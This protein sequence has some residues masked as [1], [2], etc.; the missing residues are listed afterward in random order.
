MEEHYIELDY[1]DNVSIEH[2]PLIEGH[3]KIHIINDH[4]L[5]L[6][7]FLSVYGILF[8]LH[9]IRLSNEKFNRW[10]YQDQSKIPAMKILARR[11]VE[12]LEN[13]HVLQAS[14]SGNIGTSNLTILSV[15]EGLSGLM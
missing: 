5:N 1:A 6:K 9:S 13:E 4:E 11:I 2:F 10:N 14:W 3:L 8:G 12:A 7:A 15:P